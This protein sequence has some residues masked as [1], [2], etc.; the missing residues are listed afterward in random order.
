MNV[1]S[2]AYETVELVEEV[3][4]TWLQ[5]NCFQLVKHVLTFDPTEYKIVW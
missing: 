4:M 5:I 3:K 1:E 2:L